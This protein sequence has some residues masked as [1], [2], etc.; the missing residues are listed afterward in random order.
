MDNIKS[1]PVKWTPD[2]ESFRQFHLVSGNP[3]DEDLDEVF[4]TRCY[5]DHDCCG[6]TNTGVL[7]T[8]R[9]PNGDVAVLQYGWRNL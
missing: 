9:L 3:S 4:R 8:R 7:S 5:C 6:H 1:K 2:G